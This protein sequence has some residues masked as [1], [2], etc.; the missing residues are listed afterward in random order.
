M[1]VAQR[2]HDRVAAVGQ[3]SVV[4]GDAGEA[5]QHPGRV[6]RGAAAPFVDVVERPGVGRG[7]VDPAQRGADPTPGLVEMRHLGGAQPFAS[8]GQEAVQLLRGARQQRGQPSGGHR[9][10]ETVGQALRRAFDRQVLAS[11]QIRP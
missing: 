3:V 10:G 2:M 6:H 9:R 7:D 4:H 5:G 11:Q 8:D 1:G